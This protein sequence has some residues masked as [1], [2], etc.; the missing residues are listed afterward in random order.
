MEL[1][2]NLFDGII[3]N[4]FS[5]D[6]KSNQMDEYV[7]SKEQYLVYREGKSKLKSVY[8]KSIRE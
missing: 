3:I 5:A 6:Y 4:K 2:K 7:L 1:I 8:K